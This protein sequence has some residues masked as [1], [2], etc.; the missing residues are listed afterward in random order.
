MS[1]VWG[2]PVPH[3]PPRRLSLPPAPS[4]PWNSRQPA[5][6]RHHKTENETENENENENEEEEEEEEEP[7]HPHFNPSTPTT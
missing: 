1:K 4:H 6:Q 3:S 7:H 2:T 5:T